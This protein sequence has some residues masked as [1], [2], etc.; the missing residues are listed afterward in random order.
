MA[1]VKVIKTTFLLRRG[2]S[3]VWEQNNPILQLGEPGFEFDTNKLKIGDGE[4]PWNE[5]DY[6]A[7][8]YTV[9]PTG[10]SIVVD[11]EGNLTLYGFTEA[12]YNQIPVK[13]EDGK[14][15]WVSLSTVALTGNIN[16]LT[17]SAPLV[18]Y[19]GSASDLI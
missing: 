14:I 12:S 13:G 19:G 17:Q 2:S 18:L 3:V 7:G 10:D 5:L 6:I 8:S 4:T 16:D 9:S 15:N 11:E 1:A